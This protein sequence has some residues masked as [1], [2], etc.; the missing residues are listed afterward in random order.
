MPDY[1]YLF[2]YDVVYFW[3]NLDFKSPQYNNGRSYIPCLFPLIV[4]KG[5]N[6]Y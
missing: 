4:N 2:L 1:I 6:I 5:L 3:F